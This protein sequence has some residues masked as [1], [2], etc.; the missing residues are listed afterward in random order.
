MLS[1]TAAYEAR[2]DV[3]DTILRV[4]LGLSDPPAGRPTWPVGALHDLD[5]SVRERAYAAGFEQLVYVNVGR[6]G[7]EEEADWDEPAGSS[8]RIPL[9]DQRPDLR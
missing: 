6:A 9:S 2:P 8:D 5:Q 7:P 3:G 4:R 1:A